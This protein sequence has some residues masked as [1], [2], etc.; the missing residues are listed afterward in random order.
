MYKKKRL[1]PEK[2]KDCMMQHEQQLLVTKDPNQL[3]TKRQNSPRP[4]VLL[5]PTHTKMK[6]LQNLPHVQPEPEYLSKALQKKNQSCDLHRRQSTTKL[7]KTQVHQQ[8]TNDFQ[9]H[10]FQ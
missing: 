2:W 5:P 6:L 3:T 9:L 4:R 10:P 7:I 8:K 1:A